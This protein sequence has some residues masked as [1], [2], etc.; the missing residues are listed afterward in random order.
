M[1]ITL[2]D[3]PSGLHQ[4]LRLRAEENG[5]SL[6]KE[7]MSILQVAVN[8]EKHNPRQLLDQISENRNRMNFEVDPDELKDIISEGMLHL[9]RK[10]I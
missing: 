7:V 6:N 1:N 4:K 10:R 3:I 2:K 5:R 8:P 9:R